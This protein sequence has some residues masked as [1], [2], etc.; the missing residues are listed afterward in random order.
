MRL[1]KI[2]NINKC[3]LGIS[4]FAKMHNSLE[5][6]TLRSRVQISF[7]LRENQGLTLNRRSFVVSAL[8]LR[9][10]NLF[11]NKKWMVTSKEF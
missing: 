11:F 7:S 3:I 1:K 10:E 8:G 9:E 5:I 4:Y 6:I 2:A